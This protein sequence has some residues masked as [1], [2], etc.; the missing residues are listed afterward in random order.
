MKPDFKNID[1]NKIAASLKLPQKSRTMSY[2]DHCM[3]GFLK[4]MKQA[5]YNLCPPAV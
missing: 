3:A 4:F 1:I 2:I 5:D